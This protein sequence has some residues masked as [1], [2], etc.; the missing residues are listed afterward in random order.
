VIG[1]LATLEPE[2]LVRS[3]RESGLGRPDVTIRPKH[4]GKP[5]VVLELKVARPGKKT[6][7]QALADGLAQIHANDYAAELRSAGAAPVHAFEVAF[8]G[9]RVSVRTAGG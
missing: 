6:P 9:K 4:A 1:L 8:D 5:G 2:Y 7:E 3:N